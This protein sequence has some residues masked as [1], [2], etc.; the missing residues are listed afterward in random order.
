MRLS[1]LLA[2]LPSVLGAPKAKRDA[3]APLYMV[4]DASVAI[5]D[6][7][8]VKFKED[9]SIASAGDRI[10]ILA[11]SAD[12]VYTGGALDGFAGS[13]DADTLEE[14]R[15]NP[16][17][18]HTLHPKQPPPPHNLERHAQQIRMLTTSLHPGRVH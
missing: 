9:S 10:S 16:D 15:A 2:I 4:E 8:I 6:K 14:L 5:A 3:P 13:L 18:S 11:E 17:V 12:Y 7:Y 1:F